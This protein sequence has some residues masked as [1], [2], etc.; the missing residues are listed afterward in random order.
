M[1]KQI[2]VVG[3][4]GFLGSRVARE[5]VLRGHTVSCLSRRLPSFYPSPQPSDWQSKVNYIAADILDPTSS[6]LQSAFS[7]KDA[8][9]H[10]VGRLFSDPSYKSALRSGDYGKFASIAAKE[11]LSIAQSAASCTA[12]QLG[13]S[14][15][16]PSSDTEI[17]QKSGLYVANTL[18]A[19]SSADLANQHLIPQFIYVSASDLLP[20]QTDYVK[21]KRAAERKVMDPSYGF[22][23]VVLRPGWCLLRVTE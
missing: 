6:D 14:Q 20:F 21:T 11:A 15:R 12:R 10:T 17:D 9:V 4:T 8:V 23:S 16:F 18:S 19:I 2:L 3:G 5:A 22:K 13:L 1:P 7:G